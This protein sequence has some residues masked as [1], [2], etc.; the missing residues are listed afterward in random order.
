MRLC[1]VTETGLE[2]A[3]IVINPKFDHITDKE[4][5]TITALEKDM[6]DN[7]EYFEP[8]TNYTL[9]E[10]KPVLRIVSETK[11]RVERTNGK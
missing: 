7:P 11:T 6:R 4:Y 8:N 5:P 9:H 1:K 3:T 10:D 2:F